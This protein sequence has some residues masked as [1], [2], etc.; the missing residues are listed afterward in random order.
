MQQSSFVPQVSNA[1]SHFFIQFLMKITLKI[2]IICVDLLH[3][4]LALI[5]LSQKNSYFCLNIHL[6]ICLFILEFGP[7]Q[8]TSF[9]SSLVM[10]LDF[11][12]QPSS[13][14]T[15]LFVVLQHMQQCQVIISTQFLLQAF[16]PNEWCLKNG[17]LSGGLNPGPLG[18][19]SSALTTR[20]RLLT[21]LLEYLLFLD[22]DWFGMKKYILAVEHSSCSKLLL[23]RFF[24]FSTF[25]P[26]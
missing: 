3:T 15:L 11:I 24:I 12:S 10:K 8:L 26:Y 14:S 20:P 2:T 5:S 25:R 22:K 6:F 21:Q 16:D 4:T 7:G 17:L 9:I 19:E 13:K 1:I 23:Q 18:H